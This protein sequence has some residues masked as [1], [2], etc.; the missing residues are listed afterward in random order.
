M[1]GVSMTIAEQAKK[2]EEDCERA[3]IRDALVS[4]RWDKWNLSLGLASTI[5][6]A[7]AAFLAGAGNDLLGFI[8]SKYANALTALFAM[9]SAVFASTLTFL[10]P[11]EKANSFQQTSN[12]YHSLRERLRF[13]RNTRC[14]EDNE[15]LAD[16]L[17][18]LIG[19][20]NEIDVDHPVVPEWAY[21]KA[22][23]RIEEKIMRNQKLK[24]LRSKSEMSQ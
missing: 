11:S 20:K 9:I 12:K 7:I 14:V 18:R 15:N 8:D 4:S 3:A 1:S 13:F 21:K 10:A 16:D 23:V 2:V 22:Q 6:A 17:E 24:N 19:E 5:A